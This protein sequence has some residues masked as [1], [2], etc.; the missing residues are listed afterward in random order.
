MN[1]NTILV[2]IT[3]VGWGEE[4]LYADGAGCWKNIDLPSVPA[5]FD[6]NI[7]EGVNTTFDPLYDN[8]GEGAPRGDTGIYDNRP[9]A[10]SIGYSEK[11]IYD[12]PTDNLG[13][14]DCE[15]EYD[16]CPKMEAEDYLEGLLKQNIYD[17][18][19]RA[20]VSSRIIDENPYDNKDETSV[21]ESDLSS[22]TYGNVTDN[23]TTVIENLYESGDPVYDNRSGEGGDR[24]M[25]QGIYDNH[26]GLTKEIKPPRDSCDVETGPVLGES[27]YDNSPN[28]PLCIDED[29]T[30]TSMESFKRTE[31]TGI[32]S[33]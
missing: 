7:Y 12:N 25:S 18:N 16:N 22:H 13:R 15:A 5:V 21:V 31:N 26:T 11:G 14:K 6:D 28:I 32:L 9:D 10:Q 30:Y 29:D 8:K 23:P 33:I 3:C 4:H 19:V 17:N 1:A 24:K 2:P 27:P 20:K